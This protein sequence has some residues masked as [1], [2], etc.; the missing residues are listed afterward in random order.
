MNNTYDIYD[1][2]Y[3]GN[4]FQGYNFTVDT[5]ASGEI[6]E[7]M[8]DIAHWM[9]YSV[10]REG[11]WLGGDLVARPNTPAAV[12]IY[13]TYD[14]WVA[15]NGFAVSEDPAPDTGNPWYTPDFTVY[16]FWLTDP[17]AG[18][19]GEHVYVTASE[20]ESTYFLPLTTGDKY[21]GK[22]LQVA[23][24]PVVMSDANVEIANPIPD[25]ANLEFIGVETVKES[26]VMALSFDSFNETGY[27]TKIN[28]QSWK[29]LVDQYLLSDSGAVS[30][31]E[32]T[33]MGEPILVHR[34]DD[35]SDYYLIPFNKNNSYYSVRH[36]RWR[37]KRTLTSGVIMLDTCE[38][39]FKEASWT[40]EPIE[41]LQV[42]EW[43]A[44]ILL[45]RHEMKCGRNIWRYNDINTLLVWEPSISS[46]P[47]HPVWK[48]TVDN[49]TWFITQGGQFINEAPIFEPI[50]NKAVYAGDVVEFSILATDPDG[51]SPLTYSAGSL[52]EGATFNNETFVWMPKNTQV[53]LHTI[54]FTVSD[55]ELTDSKKVNIRVLAR[56]PY[57]YPIWWRMMGAKKF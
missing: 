47:F 25:I 6:T 57:R 43:E 44:I 2:N 31:F 46:S 15:I 55:G 19:I 20:A 3:D 26:E 33:E 12:P 51:D 5:Y 14:N 53:G 24:P 23:E 21:D 29:D 34:L 18:G 48:I 13:G 16:G 28:K 7:Y 40:D 9:A 52:P 30:A 17:T 38:G 37:S 10:T 42:S 36:S 4:P 22:Y 1:S 27:G 35:E 11:W 49:N 41:Y 45:L 8:R 56:S 54:T 50:G 32:G 39:Y